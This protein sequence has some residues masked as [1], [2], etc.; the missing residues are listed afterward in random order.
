MHT[1]RWRLPRPAHDV[2]L[3]AIATGPGVT[4]PYWAIPRPYQPTSKHWESRVIGATNPIWL[5]AD[6]DGQF[7]AAREYARR[8][9]DRQGTNPAKLIPLLSNYDEAVAAQVAS[10]LS[11]AHVDLG[12]EGLRQSLM[13]AAHATRRGFES[14]AE[15][16]AV[17]HP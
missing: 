1:Y 17:S 7:T 2:H 16:S 4:A 14:Y 5:D 8:L 12:A 3:V 13:K 9:V 11:A 6:G 15:A 10:L